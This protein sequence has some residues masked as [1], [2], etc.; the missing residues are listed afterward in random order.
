MSGP[1]LFNEDGEPLFT[2]ERPGIV[3]MGDLLEYIMEM[4]N[5]YK[6]TQELYQVLQNNLSFIGSGSPK[7]VY[8]NLVALQAAKPTGDT[9]I[10][11][12][13]S[14]GKWYYWNGS[15]W[16]GGGVYQATQVPDES[17]TPLKI[18]PNVY[19]DYSKDLATVKIQNKYVN[20][21]T[22]IETNYPNNTVGGV[23]DFIPVETNQLIKYFCYSST[24]LL[25]GVIYNA[26]KQRIGSLTSPTVNN[27]F[28]EMTMPINAKFIRVNYAYATESQFKVQRYELNKTT[29]NWLNVLNEN[30]VNQSVTLEKLSLDVVNKLNVLPKSIT[31][32]KLS[33]AT[34][35]ELTTTQIENG[36][37]TLEKLSQ[38]VIDFIEEPSSPAVNPFDGNNVSWIGDSI[39]QGTGTSSNTKRFSNLVT[40]KLSFS[41]NG[42]Q[43]L[44][45][46]GSTIAK[47]PTGTIKSFTQR[48]CDEGQL[49]NNQDRIFVLGGVNDFGQGVPLSTNDLALSYFSAN[50]IWND[51]TF[52]GALH[53]LITYI[54]DFHNNSELVFILP[55]HYQLENSPNS[56]SLK[57]K[58]YVD[59]IKEV[60]SYYAVPIINLWDQL[61]IDPKN[62][63]HKN[64]YTL[65]GTLTTPD[66]IHPNDLGNAMIAKKIENFM[67]YQ[68]IVN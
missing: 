52:F 53:R 66:G 28:A 10:Y 33:D 19:M 9:N 32:D 37:V 40:S 8:A 11:V 42:Y 2:P 44:G 4:R 61:P 3:V 25:N 15:S 5:L 64:K 46:G 14:D 60:C 68:Y 18:N 7:G 35:T 34:V 39:I 48:V 62:S 36:G 49:V 43:N 17:I 22:G 24:A 67:R 47:P 31:L 38:S 65:N 13:S 45:V 50:G 1:T 23:T 12:V 27:S 55:M 26:S 20:G 54:R 63:G 41:V 57:M 51:T 56:Q 29:L 30:L 6:D 59:A 16:V 58:S 21:S